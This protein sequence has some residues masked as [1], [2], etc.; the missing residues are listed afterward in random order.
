MKK[1]WTIILKWGL[2]LGV[3]LSIIQMAR[4]FADGFD[5]YSFGPILDLINVLIFIVLIYAGT[6]EIKETI[7]DGIISFTKAFIKGVAI[8]V[9]AFIIVF[10]YLNLHYG[11][12]FKD[13]MAFVNNKRLER[14]EERI[15]QDTIRK[16]ELDSMLNIHK[17]VVKK[18]E[19]VVYQNA[20]IDS[21]NRIMI[22]ARVDSIIT[23][24]TY[25]MKNQKLN[26]DHFKLGNFDSYSRSTM[27]DISR[28]FIA[29]LPKSDTSVT[30]LSTIILNGSA[31]FSEVSVVKT[32]F[33]QDKSKIQL[34]TNSFSMAAYFSSQVLIFGILFSIFVAMYLYRKKPSNNE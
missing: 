9:T 19:Q 24:Y 5:F 4:K 10:I 23:Y 2:I 1:Q 15:K 20:A 29:K 14:M 28:K 6:K 26:E 30:Y 12:F 11:V 17:Q 13:Q 27:N 3:G 34:Y 32:R 8:V 25:F 33:D 18:Q 31:K 21:L 16:V 22:S 7:Y